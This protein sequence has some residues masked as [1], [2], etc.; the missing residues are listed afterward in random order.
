VC[1]ILPAGR[2][3]WSFGA[4]LTNGIIDTPVS[5][6]LVFRKLKSANQKEYR[7]RQSQAELQGYSE[8][9]SK[10]NDLKQVAYDEGH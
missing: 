4:P 7:T 5:K 10:R 2:D 9:A 3:S 6:P 8:K 1:R